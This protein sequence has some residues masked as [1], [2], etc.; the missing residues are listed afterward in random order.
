M[1]RSRIE[2][3]R[4]SRAAARRF[5]ALTFRRLTR[6]AGSRMTVL[7]ITMK[8]GAKAPALYHARTD[9]FF[10]VL[11][12]GARGRV[13]RLLRSFRAGDGVFLPAGTRHEFTAG[14]AGVELLDIFVPGFDMRRPDIV[15]CG[16]KTRR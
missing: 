5:G 3:T 10:F 7:H 13:G 2:I 16:P 11:R 9:E 8:P 14:P 12:G 1:P 15:L 4:L 6:R